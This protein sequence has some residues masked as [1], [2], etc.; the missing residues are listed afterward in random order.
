MNRG[1]LNDTV[2]LSIFSNHTSIEVVK[3]E[4]VHF[5]ESEVVPDEAK[6]FIE[7]NVEKGLQLVENLYRLIRMDHRDREGEL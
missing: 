6:R 3:E 7:E 5:G 2:N 1:H 4:L